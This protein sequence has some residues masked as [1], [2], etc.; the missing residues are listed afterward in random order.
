MARRTTSPL[1]SLTV[2]D[3]DR[4]GV[5]ERIYRAFVAAILDGRL[6]AGSRL[7]SSRDLAVDWRVARNTVDDALSQ[8]QSEGMVVRRVGDGTFVA[9]GVVV[10]PR[11]SATRRRAPAALGRRA[12]RAASARGTSAA[13]EFTSTSIPRAVPFVA[14][15][16]AL[17]A[18]P[19]ALWRK[20]VARRLRLSGAAL[21]GYLPASGYPPLQA[22]IADH[23]A[24]ARGIRCAPAQVMVLPSSMQAI[25]LVARVL[26]ERNDGAWVE[27]PCYPNLR[28]VLA[29]AGV[30][31]TAVDTDGEGIDPEAGLR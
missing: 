28:A 25:D 10:R 26:A 23:L 8:L 17:D 4:T 31:V 11:A 3:A 14:G 12:L 15:L 19:L 6:A 2:R 24:T 29:M 21:L 20:L 5:R 27:A 1:F 16:P 22:A 30:D 9:P 18:F 7:P 13:R